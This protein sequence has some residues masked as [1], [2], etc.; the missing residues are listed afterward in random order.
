MTKNAIAVEIPFMTPTVSLSASIVAPMATAPQHA[1]PLKLAAL[2]V[3]SSS[4]G[5]IIILSINQT[6]QSVLSLISK[7]PALTPLLQLMESIHVPCAVTSTMLPLLVPETKFS[8]I[9]Y[10]VVTPYNP[11][12]WQ[13]SLVNLVHDITYGSPIGSPPPLQETFIIPNNLVSAL[14]KPDYVSNSLADEVSSGWS[15]LN[16]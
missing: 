5:T 2:N 6:S 16:C 1:L 10:K 4:N 8:H 12:A 11:I 13:H 7:D 15:F 3:P 14:N 9:L